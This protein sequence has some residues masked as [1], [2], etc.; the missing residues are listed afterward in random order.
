MNAREPY[1]FTLLKYRHDAFAGELVNV[2]IL[3]FGHDSQKLL[4]KV[5]S[6][7]GRLRQLYVDLSKDAFVSS[8]KSIERAANR[9]KLE[10]SAL[11]GHNANVMTFARE[12]IPATD[13]SMIWGEMFSGAARDI[14]RTAEE[15]FLQFVACHDATSKAHRDDGAVWK[16]V[17]NLLVDRDIA[18]NLQPKTIV[19]DLDRVEFQHAWKNGA[20]HCYQPCSFDYESSDT[21]LDKARRWVGQ[22][23]VISDSV[24]KFKPYFLVGA[25]T[26]PELQGTYEKA[27]NI[28][29]KGPTDAHV[30]REN[31]AE[32]L[33]DLIEFKMKSHTVEN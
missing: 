1:T 6:K 25:P 32:S 5:R 15:L 8:L 18:K 9:L 12:I 22:L 26:R 11:H 24:E 27:I 28:L 4:V 14:E 23:T 17:H 31:E 30:Y 7:V 3:I 16:T 13:G 10:A 33:V 20:W 19:S 2:G 29:Q 21:I